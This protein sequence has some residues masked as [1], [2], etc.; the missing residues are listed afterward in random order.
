MYA[1]ALLYLSGAQ[2]AG[3]TTFAAQTVTGAVAVLSTNTIDLGV[4][5]DMGEGKE[6]FCRMQVGTAFAG[7]TALTVEVIVASDAALTTNITVVGSSGAI[8]VASLTASSRIAILLNPLLGSKGQRY[9]GVRY[10]P[11]GTGTTG[12]V[13]T[14]IGGGIQDGAKFYTSG[15]AVI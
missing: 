10:T 3:T 11:T 15:I 13:T 2:I 9:M 14:D 8:P 12:T 4:A 1:D 6:L 5:R 7:L